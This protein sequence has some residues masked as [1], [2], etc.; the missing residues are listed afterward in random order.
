LGRLRSFTGADSRQERAHLFGPDY[1]RTYD[2]DGPL[3]CRPSVHEIVSLLAIPET[4]LPRLRSS[5]GR[6][7]TSVN[8]RLFSIAANRR[9]ASSIDRRQGLGPAGRDEDICR[10]A[11]CPGSVSGRAWPR[12]RHGPS[13]PRLTGWFRRMRKRRLPPHGKASPT[14]VGQSTTCRVQSPSLPRCL[15]KQ[16]CA[17]KDLGVA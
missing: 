10:R 6:Q 16:R 5:T 14:V 7:G 2:I 13:W 17:D 15:Y 4:C 11:C 3:R 1:L 8:S 12:S 9:L